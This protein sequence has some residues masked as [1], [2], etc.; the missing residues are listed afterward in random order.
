MIESCNGIGQ[1]R[2]KNDDI[3]SASENTTPLSSSMHPTNKRNCANPPVAIVSKQ[4]HIKF[5]ENVPQRLRQETSS[6]NLKEGGITKLAYE[7]SA[8]RF[9]ADHFIGF[10]GCEKHERMSQNTYGMSRFTG[11]RL[12]YDLPKPDFAPEEYLPLEAR[13]EKDP[14]TPNDCKK[15]R[16]GPFSHS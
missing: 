10:K 13:V 5:T 9:L 6:N 7:E 15:M 4:Q 14:T 12:G 11:E 1:C 3:L 8:A 2:T 16:N